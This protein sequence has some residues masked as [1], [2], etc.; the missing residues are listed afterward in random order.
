MSAKIPYR[1]QAKKQ[2]RPEEDDDGA[3]LLATSNAFDVP[4]TVSGRLHVSPTTG[5]RNGGGHAGHTSARR[6]GGI[7]LRTVAEACLEAGLDP[8]VEI[9]R[10]LATRVPVLDAKGRPVLD[11]QGQIV[12]T[13][14]VD[15]D[16]K[17]RTLTELLQYNQ[18][19]LKAVEMK[20]SGALELS[21]EELDQ[22][23]A[24]LL[25]KAVTE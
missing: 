11:A 19:K 12:T 25:A 24:T 22:R 10:A 3:P 8:A 9:A 18:P 4:S 17:I 1:A 16:T 20:V 13:G 14:L 23:L 7:N 6:P 5:R 15:T 21:S 2:R